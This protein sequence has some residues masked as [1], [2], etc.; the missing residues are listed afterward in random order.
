L[1]V[2]Q[3]QQVTEDG[4]KPGE[5]QPG[6]QDDEPAGLGHLRGLPGGLEVVAARGDVD[7]GT[8]DRGDLG[9]RDGQ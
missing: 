1:L 3:Q 4:E 2:P 9:P 5:D 8:V 7:A 6:I